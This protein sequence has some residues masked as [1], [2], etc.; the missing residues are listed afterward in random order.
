M[1]D[2]IFELLGWLIWWRYHDVGK[3]GSGQRWASLFYEQLKK[4]PASSKFRLQLCPPQLLFYRLWKD[5]RSQPLF[6]ICLSAPLKII[7]YPAQPQA[8]SAEITQNG[9]CVYSSERF[10]YARLLKDIYL[11][12]CRYYPPFH[13]QTPSPFFVVLL[14]E[15][16]WRFGYISFGHSNY[17]VR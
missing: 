9:I 10:L 4:S 17:A 7:D 11:L 14:G 13:Y 2:D 16:A 8:F 1:V 3:L 15:G 6:L 5:C 12:S